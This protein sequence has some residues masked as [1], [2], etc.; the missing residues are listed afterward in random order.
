MAQDVPSFEGGTLAQALDDF[1]SGRYLQAV[2][3]F[4]RLARQGC[5]SALYS[6][7]YVAQG[8]VH[9]VKENREL[10]LSYIRKSAASDESC[11]KEGFPPAKAW[12]RENGFA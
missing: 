4:E 10:G 1:N 9:H 2:G 5:V 8:T 6:G 11:Q 12:L 3:V 7:A